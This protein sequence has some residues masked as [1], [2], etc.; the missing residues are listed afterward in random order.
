MDIILAFYIIMIYSSP[1]RLCSYFWLGNPDSDIPVVQLSAE[2]E[3]SNL[4]LIL[5]EQENVTEENEEK[6]ECIIW[7]WN[8]TARFS[9]HRWHNSAPN[10]TS[11]RVREK[12]K[13]AGCCCAGSGAKNQQK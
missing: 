6:R 10:I 11:H 7:Q 1:R 2:N 13:T 12:E 8:I 4:I 9:G 3:T 5:I